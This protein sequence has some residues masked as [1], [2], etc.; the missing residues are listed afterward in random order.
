MKKQGYSAAEIDET[1]KK[2]TVPIP[3]KPAETSFEP[4]EP[5][6]PPP[7]VDF[8]NPLIDELTDEDKKYLLL[9]WGKSYRPDEWI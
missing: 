9:K 7:E 5:G 4:S 2:G 1:L 3:E 8:G 6:F